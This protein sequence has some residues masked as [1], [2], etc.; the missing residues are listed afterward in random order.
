[1]P[2]EPAQAMTLSE[3]AAQT[4]S[5]LDLSAAGFRT[6][7][8]AWV[9]AVTALRLVWIAA[10]PLGNGEAY[11]YSWSRFLDWSYY[12]HPPLLAWLERLCTLLATSAFSVRLGP[13]LC[14]ALFGLLLYRLAERLTGPRAAFFALVVITALPVFMV[15]SIVVNPE[16]PLAPLWVA[17]LLAVEGMRDGDEPFRPLVA[18][19][20]LGLA[21][22]AKY[23]G[24][25]L[26]PATLLYFALSRRS[27]RWLGRP[28]L[29]LGGA[30]A[31]LI[32]LPVLLWNHSRGWPTLQLHFAERNLLAGAK[33]GDNAFNDLVA[34][35]SAGGS[36]FWQRLGRALVGQLLAYSPLLGPLLLLGLLASAVRSRRNDTDLFL[37]VF[38]LGA[39]VPLF[40]AMVHVKDS[41][42]HWTMVAAMSAAIALGRLAEELR[43]R[44]RLFRGLLGSG[45]ALSALFYLLINVHIHSTV[46]L[47]LLPSRRYDPHADIVN[48]LIGWDQVR[49][50]VSQTVQE[51]PGPV[52][53]AG[54]QY[55]FC[56]RLLF[57][58]DD[59]PQVY[60]LGER[61][62]E[63]DFIGRG[64]PPPDAT[65]LAVTGDARQVL[66]AELADRRCELARTVEIVRGGMTV[67][68]YAIHRCPPHTESSAIAGAEGPRA[69]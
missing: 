13:V 49:A 52:V 9:A 26:V 64:H 14:S 47:R 61:R 56:G 54:G 65:V 30:V 39:L 50:A 24:L 29:Y 6:L 41:E 40:A 27:R 37:A 62:S 63:F 46:L 23:T 2:R 67:E 38:G 60:C 35:A 44:S 32:A 55:A 8:G 43:P 7:A 4:A 36:D 45:L 68:R 5:A 33:P 28:S 48:E 53:L 69:R 17:F 58:M 51:T 12:D 15:S 22:L 11:Y 10:L 34:G 31:L 66:P 3:A 18:G 25:L 16:A 57:E 59:R 20:L 42:Q 1:M 21:F 19:A